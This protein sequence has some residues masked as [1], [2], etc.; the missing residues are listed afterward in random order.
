MDATTDFDGTSGTSVN[1]PSV[2]G[3]AEGG[4]G[5][6]WTS[7]GVDW[8]SGRVDRTTGAVVFDRTDLSLTVSNDVGRVNKPVLER[9]V[10]GRVKAVLAS[11]SIVW[12]IPTEGLEC[13][14]VGRWS[15]EEKG[16]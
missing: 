15:I 10:D 2:F 9:V 6:D 7:T 11:R 4:G 12:A 13:I 5:V 16:L 8:T 3:V 1:F 14:L